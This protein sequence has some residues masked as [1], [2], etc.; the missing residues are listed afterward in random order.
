MMDRSI[1]IR[2]QVLASLTFV[3][4]VNVYLL[5]NQIMTNEERQAEKDGFSLQK[6]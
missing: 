2:L 4:I 6:I 1:G 3:D 5:L